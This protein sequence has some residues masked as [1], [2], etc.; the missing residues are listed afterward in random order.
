[1]DEVLGAALGHDERVRV[2]QGIALER[3]MGCFVLG[4]RLT[5]FLQVLVVQ[6][7]LA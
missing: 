2:P 1:M 4:K 3:F 7:D 5:V 6:V